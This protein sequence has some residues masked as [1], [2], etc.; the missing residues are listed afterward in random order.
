MAIGF[1]SDGAMGELDQM[2]RIWLDGLRYILLQSDLDIHITFMIIYIPQS[3]FVLF[4]NIT[5]VLLY[6]GWHVRFQDG[7]YLQKHT[8]MIK[9][10]RKRIKQD[11]TERMNGYTQVKR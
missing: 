4:L 5:L 10:L 6:M 9:L 2:R 8:S 11:W 7:I 3:C 1:G